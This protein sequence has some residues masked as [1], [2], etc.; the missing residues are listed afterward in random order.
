MRVLGI[1]PGRGSVIWRDW[2]THD[3]VKTTPGGLTTLAAPLGHINVHIRDGSVIL[4]HAEPGYTT[5]ET[6]RGPFSLLVSQSA[7]GKAFGSA[8]IDDGISYPPGPSRILSFVV[9]KGR[10]EIRGRGEFDVEQILRDIVVL[11]VGV[12]PKRVKVGGRVVDGK[13]WRFDERKEKLEVDVRVD[14][15]TD[16]TLDWN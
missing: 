8:Y 10:L 2:Y 6:R 11:G 14:L 12:K 15:N 7:E 9:K 13:R 3:V 4:L 1:F 5:E 16:T